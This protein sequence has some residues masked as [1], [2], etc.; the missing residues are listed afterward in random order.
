MGLSH[1]TLCAAEAGRLAEG[2]VV[3]EGPTSN[4][5][6][7]GSVSCVDIAGVRDR[8][9]DQLPH[10]FYN[11]TGVTTGPADVAE[12]DGDLYLLTGEDRGRLSHSLLRITDPTTPPEVVAD[13]LVYVTSFSQLLHATGDGAVLR[14]YPDGSFA[15][16]AD[17]L[18]API[19]LAFVTVGRLYVLAFIDGTETSDPC[20]GKTGRLIRLEPQGDGWTE[21]RV[22][23]QDMPV[24]TSRPSTLWIESTSQSM[25]PSAHRTADWCCDSMIWRNERRASR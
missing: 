12:M 24:P 11:V 13:F 20:H 23:V 15:V 25:A 17:N 18:T 8:I 16:A 19:D 6:H 7:T 14:L 21:G 4:P 3:R 1:A 22:L 10:V 5:A 9:I 2:Q